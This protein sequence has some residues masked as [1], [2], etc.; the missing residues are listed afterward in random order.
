MVLDGA[1]IH[2]AN[3]TKAWLQAQGFNI[4]E[5]WPSHSPDL[6]PIE[7]WWAILKQSLGSLLADDLSNTDE[8]RARVWAAVKAAA[9]ECD[10]ECLTNLVVSFERRLKACVE[11]E[12][13]W[14]GY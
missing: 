10:K 11:R 3:H 6:N 4:V 5:D 9:A 2:T 7:N 8:N 12:G 14:T 13:G 1:S